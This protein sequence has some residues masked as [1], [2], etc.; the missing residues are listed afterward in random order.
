MPVPA[1]MLMVLFFVYPFAYGLVLSFT[2]M[3]GGGVLANYITFFTDT[4]CAAW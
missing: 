4:W 3:N 1:A 2:P